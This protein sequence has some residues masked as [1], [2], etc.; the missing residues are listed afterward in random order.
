MQLFQPPHKRRLNCLRSQRRWRAPSWR[1]RLPQH[2][3][4]DAANKCCF[5][6]CKQCGVTSRWNVMGPSTGIPPP[7]SGFVEFCRLQR[8]STPRQWFLSLIT[9]C[10]EISG[11][12]RGQLWLVCWLCH[13]SAS[14][15]LHLPFLLAHCSRLLQL[16]LTLQECLA[17][18][19]LSRQQESSP[20][21][22]C[23]LMPSTKQVGA[24]LLSRSNA[25][26]QQHKVQQH[27]SGFPLVSCMN[28]QFIEA[29]LPFQHG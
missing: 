28:C 9:R 19:Q 5:Q 6:L 7:W 3:F 26:Q 13:A 18:Q 24:A 8:S 4:L 20:M 14:L 2:V 23:L 27:T 1:S 10:F 17:W 25:G 29:Q 12:K 16:L 15:S 21:S 11:C 22:P